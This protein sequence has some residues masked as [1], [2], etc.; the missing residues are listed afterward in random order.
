MTRSS[1]SAVAFSNDLASNPETSPHFSRISP[2]SGNRES[3]FDDPPRR[4][5]REARVTAITAHQRLT[6]ENKAEDKEN[7]SLAVNARLIP[8]YFGSGGAP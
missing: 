7:V 8:P 5:A 1:A 3:S 2:V 4:Q 6:T